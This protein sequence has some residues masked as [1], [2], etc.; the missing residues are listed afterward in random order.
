MWTRK[1]TKTYQGVNRKDIWEVW[2]DIDKW[3]SWHDDLEYCRLQGEFSAGNSFLLKPK[4]SPAVKIRLLEVLPEKSFTDCASFPL[5]KMYNTHEIEET[6]AGLKLTN[7]LTVKG[8]LKHLWIK[9]VAKNVADSV[10]KE[11]DSLVAL[12]RKRNV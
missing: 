4:G 6:E 1:Y 5:A 2:S 11:M 3:A 10:P 8:L 9:L 7:I 12:A